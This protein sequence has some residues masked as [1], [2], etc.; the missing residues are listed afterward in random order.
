MAKYARIA[1]FEADEAA[2]NAVVNE[3]NS[4]GGRPPEGVPATSFILLSDRSAGKALFV[5]G[6]D[7]EED[8]RQG[9]AALDAMSPPSGAN[10]RRL[11]V[12]MYDVLLERQA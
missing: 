1:T 7:S 5:V 4:T 9:S 10:M 3:V 2:L 8:L 6:F 11:S 12:E